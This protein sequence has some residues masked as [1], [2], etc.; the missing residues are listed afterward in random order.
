MQI[1]SIFRSWRLGSC[2]DIN[3]PNRF[4]GSRKEFCELDSGA[5][6]WTVDR[7]LAQ[8]SPRRMEKAST[9]QTVRRPTTN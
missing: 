9:V 2:V 3:G 4:T 7:F 6:I 1:I 8:K 5:W